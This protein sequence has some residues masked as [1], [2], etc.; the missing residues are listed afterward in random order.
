[1]VLLEEMESYRLS[2]YYQELDNTTKGMFAKKQRGWQD[3][4]QRV[5]H[6]SQNEVCKVI[7]QVYKIG[8]TR[9][10]LNTQMFTPYWSKTQAAY[11]SLHAYN[12]NCMA[13]S[14]MFLFLRCP[15]QLLCTWLQD[16]YYKALTKL[17]TTLLKPWLYV[18]MH[19]VILHA[20]YIPALQSY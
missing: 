10:G 11:E 15:V 1:M 6:V 13:G 5:I 19:R 17:S 8:Q 20:M 2:S 14:V 18:K 4:T 16:K 9:L 12:F 3:W 7:V